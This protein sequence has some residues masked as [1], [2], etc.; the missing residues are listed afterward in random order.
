MSEI[1]ILQEDFECHQ[2]NETVTITQEILIHRSSS[3]GEIDAR[4][5]RSFD[6][7]HA[8]TCGVGK[9]TGKKISYDWSKCIYQINR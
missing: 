1:D 8:D 7:S 2:A 3:T 4:A 6:C 5:P 9:S